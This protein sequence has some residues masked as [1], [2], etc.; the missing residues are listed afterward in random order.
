MNSVKTILIAFAVLC[1]LTYIYLFSSSNVNTDSKAISVSTDSKAIPAN[2][3][4]NVIPVNIDSN[5]TCVD[6]TIKIA[7]YPEFILC[8]IKPY[9]STHKM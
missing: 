1:F 7:V 2:T 9:H 4:S 5:A 3:D 8:S 6:N